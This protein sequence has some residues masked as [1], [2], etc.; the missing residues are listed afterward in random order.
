MEDFLKKLES[1]N[2][3]LR[4]LNF[5][6]INSWSALDNYTRIRSFIL[7]GV[8]EISCSKWYKMFIRIVEYLQKVR[9]QNYEYLL[10][11]TAFKGRCKPFLDH[12]AAG[13][14][15]TG[16]GL[17]LRVPSS[18]NEII[19]AI[20]KILRDYSYKT[21]DAYLVVELTP[22]SASYHSGDII[23][24]E[25]NDLYAFLKSTFVR[26]DEY[27]EKA[28][29]AIEAMNETLKEYTNTTYN[30]LY[31][32]S[33]LDYDKYSKEAIEKQLGRLNN[34]F[35][36]RELNLF[37]GWLYYSRFCEDDY[38]VKKYKKT[39]GVYIKNG[40]VIIEVTF[41]THFFSKEDNDY[42]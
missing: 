18:A 6:E 7:D 32:L 33:D 10:G 3:R 24:Q 4:F 42:E 40:G 26:A 30:N 37:V 16:F 5:S 28:I 20:K 41:E 8:F 29:K 22:E 35:T 38:L 1:E 19:I 12:R 25:Q 15:E 21:S 17:Y 39:S 23:K 27:Y 11:L 34:S 13:Y 14:I 31:L 36:R 9:P 2:F